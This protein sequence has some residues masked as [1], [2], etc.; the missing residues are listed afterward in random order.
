MLKKAIRS[1]VTLSTFTAG[2]DGQ[3]NWTEIIIQTRT[4]RVEER[5]GGR[6]LTLNNDVRALTRLI[7]SGDQT[8]DHQDDDM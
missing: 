7:I 5:Q 1:N 8:S 6:L 2:V 4:R 3:N